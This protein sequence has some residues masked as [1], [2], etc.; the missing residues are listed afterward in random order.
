MSKEKTHFAQRV[1][2]KMIPRES[3]ENGAYNNKRMEVL[4]ETN[5]ASR[6]VNIDKSVFRK[7]D[8][9]RQELKLAKLKHK[10]DLLNGK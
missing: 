9:E 6:M 3:S 8:A 10:V 7:T 4:A 2:V 1:R 5:A